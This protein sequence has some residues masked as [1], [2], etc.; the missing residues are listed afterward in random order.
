MNRDS[1][2]VWVP[3]EIWEIEELGWTEKLLLALVLHLDNDEGCFAS[4]EY[5]AKRLLVSKDRITRMVSGLKQKGY[6]TVDLIYKEGTKAVEKRVIKV[7]ERYRYKY[8]EGIGE[9]TER[10]PV[11]TPRIIKR[12]IKSLIKRLIL[13]YITSKSSCLIS[14][15]IYMTKK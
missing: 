3:I 11:K 15:G 13:I 1:Q 9:N 12:L 10:V 8:R 5:L 7:V 2:G 14:G 4:N 6:I